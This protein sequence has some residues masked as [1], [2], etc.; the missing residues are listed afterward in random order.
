MDSYGITIAVMCVAAVLAA[1][2]FG[3]L[4][5]RAASTCPRCGGPVVDG[6]CATCGGAA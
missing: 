1:M 3:H 5:R 4:L 6:K 2:A